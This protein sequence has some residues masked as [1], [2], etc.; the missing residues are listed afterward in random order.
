MQGLFPNLKPSREAGPGA[1]VGGDRRLAGSPIPAPAPYPGCLLSALLSHNLFLTLICCKH[2]WPRLFSPRY[3]HRGKAEERLG[4]LF[5]PIL[6]LFETSGARRVPIAFGEAANPG[7]HL[8]TCP[9]EQAGLWGML[10]GAH[11][12][13]QPCQTSHPLHPRG[14]SRATTVQRWLRNHTCDFVWCRGSP[15]RDHDTH[16]SAP[17]NTLCDPADACASVVQTPWSEASGQTRAGH[18]D[19]TCVLAAAE[20][21]RNNPSLL[22]GPQLL[23]LPAAEQ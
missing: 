15:P 10:S 3:K 16:T 18:S 4:S 7:P 13:E 21:R 19:F 8:D 23:L 14:P 12:P 9:Q 17:A 1:A 5:K 20:G 2:K 6:G 22:R 11:G